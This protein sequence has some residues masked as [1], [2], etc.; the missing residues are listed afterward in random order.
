MTMTL[1]PTTIF[2]VLTA[3]LLGG[4]VL[5]SQF[6]PGSQGDDAASDGD[7]SPLFS[8]EESQVQAFNVITPG[9]VLSFEKDA[10]NTWQMT[11]PQQAKANPATVAFLLS[12]LTTAQS[13]RT[14]TV[15]TAS[16]ADYGFSQFLATVDLQ[17][18]EPPPQSITLGGYD[19][20]R[21]AI[22]SL[23]NPPEEE[24]AETSLALVA[25]DILEAIDRPIADW[26]IPA[27]TTPASPTASPS[28]PPT[29]TPTVP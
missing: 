17:L 29:P 8:F 25:P 27:S 16:L 11:K 1:K 20:N 12:R 3:M 13:T 4:V 24:G 28:Q 21:S 14:V 15:P 18:T 2:L 5:V 26:L 23:V 19:F 7:S 9:Q 6:Y 22:Y 10:Q